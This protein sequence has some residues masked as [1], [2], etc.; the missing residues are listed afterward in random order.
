MKETEIVQL[1]QQGDTHAF[2][3]LFEDYKRR[4]FTL[5]FQYTKNKEDAEDILQETFI[6]AFHS[7]DKFKAQ[8][9]TNF[10]SWLYR[11]GINTSIDHLRKNKMKKDNTIDSDQLPNISSVDGFSHPEH[12]ARIKEIRTKLDVT[13]NKLPKGQRMV[14]ILRHYQQ[15]PVKEIAEYMK[16]SE[17]SVKKQLFRA[18][19]MIKKHFK[20]LFQEDNYEMQ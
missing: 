10:S 14:F 11:I 16:C 13:L 8:D 5:A 4:V 3:Q 17:G 20:S 12:A 15:L 19:Q 2:R 6:K 9:D 1:A 18:F 7:L